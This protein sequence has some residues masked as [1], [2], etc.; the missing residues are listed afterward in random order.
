VCPDATLYKAGRDRVA[1]LLRQCIDT[2]ELH[3]TGLAQSIRAWEARNASFV[4]LPP[5]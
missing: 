5:S 2:A 1:A 4:V 3:A